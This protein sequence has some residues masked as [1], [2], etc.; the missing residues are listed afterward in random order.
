MRGAKTLSTPCRAEL[1]SVT[2]CALRACRTAPSCSSEAA[3]T[4][5]T[6]GCLA[7]WSDYPT[8][9]NVASTA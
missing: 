9:A 8:S 6:V 4:F 7:G 1:S 2:L 5:S 3:M